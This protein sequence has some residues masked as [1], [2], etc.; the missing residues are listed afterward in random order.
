MSADERAS[1][2]E[3]RKR[4]ESSAMAQ[5]T[6]AGEAMDDWRERER[7]LSVNLDELIFFNFS[8]FM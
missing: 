5:W 8:K 4:R 6:F 7:M 3:Q 1:W 2:A